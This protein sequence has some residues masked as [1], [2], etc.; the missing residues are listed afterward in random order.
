MCKSC[1]C[2]Y[3]GKKLYGYCDGFFGHD[4]YENKRIEA[5]GADWVV[6]RYVHSNDVD[7]ASFNNDEL[8]KRNSYLE[9]WMKKE[10]D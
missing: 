4:S 9:T 8:D 7:F 10:T 2:K 5:I 1:D 3:I 6:V